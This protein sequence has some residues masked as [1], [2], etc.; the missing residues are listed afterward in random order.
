MPLEAPLDPVPERVADLNS[1]YRHHSA[2]DVLAH[3]LSD[4]QV[5]RIAM[6]S[7]FGPSTSRVEM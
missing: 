5:G 4:P 1:R 3:A 6:V 2:T 7:S